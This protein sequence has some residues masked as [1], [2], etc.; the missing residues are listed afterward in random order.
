MLCTIYYILYTTYYML[1]T[2]YYILYTIYYVLCTTAQLNSW[3]VPLRA[4]TSLRTAFPGQIWLRFGF[5]TVSIPS[6]A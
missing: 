2:I 6:C 1:C 5:K 3:K 4:D